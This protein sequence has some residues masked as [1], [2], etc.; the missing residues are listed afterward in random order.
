MKK[1]CRRIARVLLLTVISLMIGGG[2]YLWNARTLWRNDI[3]MPFGVG[4][5]VVLSG[6]MEPTLQINDLVIIR[7]AETYEVGDI[8]VYQ[9]G[10]MSVIHRLIALEGGMALTQGDANNAPDEPIPAK[11]IQGK[12]VRRVPYAGIAVQAIQSLPG[13]L[14]IVALAVWLLIRSRQNEKAEA[15]AELDALRKE[16]EA[17]REEQE[18]KE[19]PKAAEEPKD[20]AEQ[21]E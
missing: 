2:V 6:S 8:V 11:S 17:L 16:I 3:P 12:L 21:K 19:A 4:A 20:T 1:A 9:S 5:S 15:Q 14:T 13:T 18:E 7:A 10:R